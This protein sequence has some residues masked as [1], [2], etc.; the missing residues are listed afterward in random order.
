M[1]RITSCQFLYLNSVSVQ[2]YFRN[3]D[4]YFNMIVQYIVIPMNFG[5]AETYFNILNLAITG[6]S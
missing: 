4:I 2:K 3:P 6:T 5:V 1:S